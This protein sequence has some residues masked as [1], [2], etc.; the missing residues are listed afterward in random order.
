M[1][2]INKKQQKQQQQQFYLDLNLIFSF[3]YL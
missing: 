2:N 3:R 1:I